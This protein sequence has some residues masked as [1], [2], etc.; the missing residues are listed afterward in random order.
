MKRHIFGNEFYTSSSDAVCILIHTGA[1][2]IHS[3]P[4]SCGAVSVYFK[5]AKNRNNY[6][7]CFKNGLKS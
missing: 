1:Y 5:V 7:N 6:N 3:I 2:K 4:P